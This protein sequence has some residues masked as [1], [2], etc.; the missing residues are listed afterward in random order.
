MKKL[1]SGFLALCLVLSMF[2]SNFITKAEDKFSKIILTINTS[3]ISGENIDKLL[4]NGEYEKVKEINSN[5]LNIAKEKINEIIGDFKELS[6]DEFLLPFISFEATKTQIAKLKNLDFIKRIEQDTE[7]EV[8]LKPNTAKPTPR[9]AAHA[10]KL[11]GIDDDFLKN[12]MDVE[13]L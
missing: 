2:T 8:D 13:K 12:M 5:S 4:K 11:I 10:T 3:K 6:R 9:S 7:Y 1:F